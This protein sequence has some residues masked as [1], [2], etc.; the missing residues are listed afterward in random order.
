MFGCK[1]PPRAVCRLYVF[2]AVYALFIEKKKNMDELT[3]KTHW[4][5]DIFLQLLYVCVFEHDPLREKWGSHL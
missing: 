4:N 5:C 3:N 1:V 2:R